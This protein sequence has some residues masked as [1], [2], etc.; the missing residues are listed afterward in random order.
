MGATGVMLVT[1]TALEPEARPH[2]CCGGNSI[3]APDYDSYLGA[4]GLTRNRHWDG[5]S[6]RYVPSRC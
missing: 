3:A 1:D 2:S 6:I 5:G 4:F